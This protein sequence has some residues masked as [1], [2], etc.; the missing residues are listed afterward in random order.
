MNFQRG[1]NA[2]KELKK[3]G[4]FVLNF[5]LI[6]A[7]SGCMESEEE[8]SCLIRPIVLDAYTNEPIN[9]AEIIIAEL[10]ECYV[11][12]ET[13][14]I[15]WMEVTHADSLPTLFTI[16]TTAPGYLPNMLYFICPMEDDPRNGPIIYLFPE[17]K[18][19]VPSTAMVDAPRQEYTAELIK[20]IQEKAKQQEQ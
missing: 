4:V 20:Q 11:T 6:V 8:Y 19:S 10:N 13:G 5:L 14:S 15:A 9:G 3:F 18:E 16:V 2:M 12:D 1:E 17:G 7:I